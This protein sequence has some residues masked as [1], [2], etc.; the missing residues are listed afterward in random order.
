MSAFASF[1]NGVERGRFPRLANR[2]DLWRLLVTI[3]A[4]KSMHLARDERSQKRGGG[5]VR[6]SYPKSPR[7]VTA[8]GGAAG[9]SIAGALP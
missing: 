7:G 6:D 4:R 5:A 3:T 2:D 1:C 9:A 8:S